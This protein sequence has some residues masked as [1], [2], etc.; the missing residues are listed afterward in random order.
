[1][2]AVLITRA[3][4]ATS[5]FNRE[6]SSSGLPVTGSN[7]VLKRDLQQQRWRCT[8]PLYRWAGRDDV[9]YHRMADADVVALEAEFGRHGRERFL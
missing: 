2:P 1:M 3:H 5:A 9:R 8:D 4:L 7:K 6:A